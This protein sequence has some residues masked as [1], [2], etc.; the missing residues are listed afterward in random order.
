MPSL[1]LDTSRLA[2]LPLEFFTGLVALLDAVAPP[3][4][5]EAMTRASLRDDGVEVVLAHT[6]TIPFSIWAQA[7]RSEIVIGC[8]AMHAECPDAAAALRMVDELLHGRR[9]VRGYD[10]AALRPT[11]VG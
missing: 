8:S 4:L 5:D 11:F 9:E 6:T 3:L 1:A 10:G 7:S 2:P